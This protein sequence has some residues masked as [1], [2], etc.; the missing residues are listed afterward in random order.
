MKQMDQ[1][2][3]WQLALFT[4]A[5]AASGIYIGF[6]SS[7]VKLSASVCTYIAVL[8][9]VFLNLIFLVAGP[10]ARAAR[11][12][13]H[14]QQIGVYGALYEALAEQPLLTAVCILQLVGASRSASTTVQILQA[15]QSGYVRGV[16]NSGT[17]A[18]RLRVFSLLMGS[19]ALL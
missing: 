2:S 5:I 14:S 4:N 15:L 3:I 10:R 12:G 13:G 11:R 16:P 18:S 1:W 19:V 7:R 8:T 9:L 6:V 17:L